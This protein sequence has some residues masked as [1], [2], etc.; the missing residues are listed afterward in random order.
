MLPL[1]QHQLG[2]RLGTKVK[3]FKSYILSNTSTDSKSLRIFANN[4]NDSVKHGSLVKWFHGSLEITV[5]F[6]NFPYKFHTF[7]LFMTLIMSQQ[8]NRL[9]WKSISIQQTELFFSL[10]YKVHMRSLSVY[11]HHQY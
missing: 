10:C 2:K 11:Q 1:L 3:S 9:H 6:C 5:R 4:Q 7:N 8:L